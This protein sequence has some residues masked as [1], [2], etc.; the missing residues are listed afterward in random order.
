MLHR[1]LSGVI[2]ACIL[3]GAMA[4]TKDVTLLTVAGGAALGFGFGAFLDVADWM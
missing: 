2:G 1:I 3:G 4:M